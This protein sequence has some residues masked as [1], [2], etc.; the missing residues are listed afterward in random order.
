MN[1]NENVSQKEFEKGQRT[2]LDLILNH[3][4]FSTLNASDY[5]D[6]Y[7]TRETKSR[8]YTFMVYVNQIESKKELEF[9]FEHQLSTIPIEINEYK[10]DK[11]N[12]TEKLE[13]L[14]GLRIDAFEQRIEELKKLGTEILP[15][16]Y[17]NYVVPK[18]HNIDTKEE[19]IK[20]VKST[21]NGLNYIHFE[22]K[23]DNLIEFCR[24][25][26]DNG[27]IKKIDARVFK[28]FFSQ[29]FEIGSKMIHW[30]EDDFM[31]TDFIRF[32]RSKELICK[33]EKPFWCKVEDVFLDKDG[34]R[35]DSE[36]L[37]NI[38]YKTKDEIKKK[39]QVLLEKL[40]LRNLEV[41]NNSVQS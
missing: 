19:R 4:M 28:N 8:I 41:K 26:I 32:L 18:E 35:V 27:F 38:T 33:K 22:Q 12:Q 7:L 24:D 5:A 2:D 25:L 20:L 34:N 36:N 15:I 10:Y 11:L 6:E 17:E 21:N 3:F 31:L 16:F 14:E 39:R 9:I 23:Q 29:K 40:T 13:Y 37:R 1:K 30:N